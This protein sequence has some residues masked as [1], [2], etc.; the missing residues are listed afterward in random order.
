MFLPLTALE[1][2]I[3]MVSIF[4]SMVVMTIQGDLRDINLD[5]ANIPTLLGSIGEELPHKGTQ[6]NWKLKVLLDSLIS[7][8]FMSIGVLV[9]GRD[10]L[11]I[12]WMVFAI[13]GYLKAN[14]MV[15]KAEQGEIE[16][17]T[18]YITYYTSLVLVI[19]SIGLA[20]I[21]DVESVIILLFG[22]IIWGMG[23]Q[24]ILYGDRAQFG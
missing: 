7:A 20:S 9:W 2:G 17:V 22:S 15:R 19:L 1:L 6:V 3:F 14:E 8:K 13:V 11:F 16:Q 4:L 24:K 5:E 21:S 18:K 10:V 12:I 23:C